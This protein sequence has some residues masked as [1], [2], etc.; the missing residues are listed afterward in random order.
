MSRKAAFAGHRRRQDRDHRI[1][2]AALQL[3]LQ[4]HK[5]HDAEQHFHKELNEDK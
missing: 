2:E 1:V 5:V 3:F 4:I